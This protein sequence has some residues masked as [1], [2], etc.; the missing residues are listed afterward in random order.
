VVGTGVAE[1][2]L[3]VL[4]TSQK[5]SLEHLLLQLMLLGSLP[6]CVRRSIPSGRPCNAPLL[7]NELWIHILEVASR[8][9]IIIGDESYSPDEIERC[10]KTRV[11]YETAEL[12]RQSFRRNKTRL[13]A[14]CWL[15]RQLVDSIVERE[16]VL[17]VCNSEP[18]RKRLEETDHGD[19]HGYRLI[20]RLNVL[21]SSATPVILNHVHPVSSLTLA[22]LPKTKGHELPSFDRLSSVIHHPTSLRSLYLTLGEIQQM[23]DCLLD[24]I[25]QPDIHL[26][27]L[28]LKTS[29]TEI[30]KTNLAFLYLTTLCI[31]V[32]GDRLQTDLRQAS[33]TLPSLINLSLEFTIPIKRTLQTNFISRLIADHSRQLCSIRLISSHNGGLDTSALSFWATF[34]RLEVIATDFS[35]LFYDKEGT[36]LSKQDMYAALQTAWPICPSFR[37]LIQNG[38]VCPSEFVSGLKRAI[39]H[40]P[41]LDTVSLAPAS[42]HLFGKPSPFW[43]FWKLPQEE[44]TAIRK[45]EKICRSRGVRILDAEG[46]EMKDIMKE[47]G[48]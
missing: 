7:P 20:P 21:F 33:W 47:N 29:S 31:H 23:P 2:K 39:R 6:A 11:S 22:I 43:N 32:E 24:P 27:T 41:N 17:D 35:S 1:F 15:W 36:P 10:A 40:C 25:A 13:R 28:S 9:T 38:N 12:A 19:L 30:L 3:L 4:A 48:F 44:Y 26:L 42:G 34:Q 18:S 5:Q 16:W 37:H 8:P 46:S 45:L 14:V